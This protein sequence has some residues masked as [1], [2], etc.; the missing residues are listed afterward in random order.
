[1][2]AIG[3]Y[4]DLTEACTQQ[5]LATAYMLSEKYRE[6]LQAMQEAL[7][8]F[9]KCEEEGGQVRV[10]CMMGETYI[11]M[12]NKKKANEVLE[13]ALKMAKQG[14]FEEDASAISELLQ[15][16]KTAA[17]T[18]MVMA[19]QVQ[20]AQAASAAAG[21]D[22]VKVY[23]PP[24]AD[25]II[26]RVKMM[27]ADVAGDAEPPDNDTPFMDAGIDSLSSVELR[28]SL[29]KA[30]GLQLPSTVMFNYPTTN[31]MADY[32]VE[33]MTANEIAF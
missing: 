13:G 2:G 18:Q 1:M 17:P 9:R 11:K 29:Q 22:A 16:T 4:D 7:I 14:N 6:A 23:V 5:Y 33:E 31:A 28:T 19:D 32:I 15:K 12:S 8:L 10:L 27:V 20:Q 24:T 26:E 30:L 21:A 3:N 25:I